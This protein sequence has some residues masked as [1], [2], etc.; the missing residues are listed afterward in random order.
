MQ[1]AQQQ[2]SQVQPQQ[3]PTHQQTQITQPAQNNCVYIECAPLLDLQEQR[4]DA[5]GTINQPLS[6]I[7]YNIPSQ[8]HLSLTGYS[9]PSV[10]QVQVYSGA[11]AMPMQQMQPSTMLQNSVV[12]P[13]VQLQSQLPQLPQP[14]EQIPIQQMP[15][16]Q[17][18]EQ[19]EKIKRNGKIKSEVKINDTIKQCS[20]CSKVFPTATKLSRHMKTHSTDMPYKCKVCNKAFSHSGNY[21]IHLRMHTDERPFRC[22]VCNKG[23]RQ[24]QDL[25]KHMRTHTGK[26]NK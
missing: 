24:A 2:L 1:Q 22:A 26:F 8:N 11:Y 19:K 10:G 18:S 20:V 6:Q 3:Q 16:M 23:C 21:K 14:Q 17:Q 9:L 13:P 12:V 5:L 4:F 15:L 25:E 7:N